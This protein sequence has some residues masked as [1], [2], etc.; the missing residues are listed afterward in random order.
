MT[1]RYQSASEFKSAL[2]GNA[3]CRVSVGRSGCDINMP[4]EYISGHHLDVIWEAADATNSSYKVTIND[5]S[6]NGT[7]VNGRKINHDSYTFTT[8]RLPSLSGNNEAFPQ[9]M[10]AGL[11]D[12]VLDWRLV[13]DKLFRVMDV[14]TSVISDD[15]WGKIPPEPETGP[16]VRVDE[17]TTLSGLLSFFVPFYGWAL[18]YANRNE[19]PIKARKANK[20]AWYGVLFYIVIILLSNI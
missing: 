11:P 12:Y 17:L 9:V 15:Q 6:R 13:A 20:M 3:L 14:H 1:L 8:N 7:G 16:I 5:H 10:L 19:K 18:Y 4:G 2:T